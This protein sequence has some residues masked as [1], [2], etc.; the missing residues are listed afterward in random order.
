MQPVMPVALSIFFSLVCGIGL[1]H[2]RKGNS[3]R[4]TLSQIV[5]TSVKGLG[6]CAVLI[7]V[8]SIILML[9]ASWYRLI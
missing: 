6:L 2:V 8:L 9:V 7:G 3:W 4:V 5:D 1:W